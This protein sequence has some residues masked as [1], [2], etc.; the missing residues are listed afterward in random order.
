MNF[1]DQIYLVTPLGRRVS[2]V[3]TELPD[4]FD[5]VVAGAVNLD[6]VETI[7]AGNLAA[8]I[9]FTARRDRRS[10]HAIERLCQNPCSRCFPDAAWT[11]EEVRVSEAILGNRVFQRARDVRLPDQII[12]SLRPIFSGENLVTH[13]FNL[14]ASAC[15]GNRKENSNH[16]S[17]RMN[18]NL[19]DH[20]SVIS[21]ERWTLDVERWTFSACLERRHL[22]WSLYSYSRC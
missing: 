9:T 17:T 1:V 8:V 18:T 4:V 21:I 15:P 10:F 7:A 6:H 19:E 3:L 22:V 20:N 12:E 11:D 14:T 5:T 13:A 16:E 2:N